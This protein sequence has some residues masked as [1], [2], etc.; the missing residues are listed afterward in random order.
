MLS[1]FAH[2]EQ[3]DERSVATKVNS[4]IVGDFIINYFEFKELTF[5]NRMHHLSLPLGDRG[6]LPLHPSATITFHQLFYIT[7]A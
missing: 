2:N 1:F 3:K 5:K 6:F 4:S 7:S